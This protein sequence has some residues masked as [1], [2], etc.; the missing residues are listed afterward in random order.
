[1]NINC[2]LYVNGEHHFKIQSGWHSLLFVHRHMISAV[3]TLFTSPHRA[4]IGNG[5]QARQYPHNSPTQQFFKPYGKGFLNTKSSSNS[6]YVGSVARIQNCCQNKK[7]AKRINII[8]RTLIFIIHFDTTTLSVM[9]IQHLNFGT[10][11]VDPG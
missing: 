3:V 6:K 2:Y 1:M 7:A 5:V 4:Q 9:N 11:Y 10:I 8:I